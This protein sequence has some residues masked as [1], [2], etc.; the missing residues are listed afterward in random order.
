[1][2][3]AGGHRPSTPSL[4]ERQIAVLRT[5]ADRC[6]LLVVDVQRSFG[7][8]EFLAGQGLGPDVLDAVAGAVRRCAGLVDRA[9]AHGV[10]VVWVEL[11]S[12]PESH[13]AAS[14]WLHLGETGSPLPDPPCLRGTA[15]A[16]WYRLRPAAG[17]LRIVKR[18]YSGF[19][20]TRLDAHLSAAG[21]AWVA[22]A[23][24]TTECCVA[25]TAFDAFQRDLPV[26][27]PSD[28]TAAYSIPL[29][30]ATLDSLARNA[31]IVMPAADLV[32]LWE[33]VPA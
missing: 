31:A 32:R 33:R 21:T 25:A 8:P 29:H 23:G 22:V 19:V 15:G 30:R 2:S 11:E 17:E 10:P 5:H 27:V 12:A 9:R 20:G 24:L 14:S 28:A 6:A 13:W 16:Q 7:D 4:P 26:V 1:M 3:A 18:R